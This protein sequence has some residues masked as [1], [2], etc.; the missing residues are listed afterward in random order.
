MYRESYNVPALMRFNKLTRAPVDFSRH[1][2]KANVIPL[3]EKEEGKGGEKKEGERE[4][5]GDDI[6]F[7]R[8]NLLPSSAFFSITE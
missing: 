7:N 1:W 8:L 4:R 5:K 3:W 2:L 6:R